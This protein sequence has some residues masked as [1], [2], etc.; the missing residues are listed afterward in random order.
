M[1]SLADI[2]V[3]GLGD[4]WSRANRLV[5]ALQLATSIPNAIDKFSRS[6]QRYKPAVNTPPPNPAGR[7]MLG[8]PPEGC[9]LSVGPHSRPGQAHS[10]LPERSLSA[11][12]LF[13]LEGLSCIGDFQA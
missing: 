5:L 4:A 9:D 12:P 1:L 2:T 8:T 6:C 10:P 13:L 7:A 3:A 11:H